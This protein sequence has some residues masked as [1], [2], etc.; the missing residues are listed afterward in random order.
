MHTIVP[1]IPNLDSRRRWVVSLMPLPLCASVETSCIYWI[2]SWGNPRAGPDALQK[3]KIIWSCQDS[4]SF[5]PASSLDTIMTELQYS[6]VEYT[7]IQH[8][9]V[10]YSKVRYSTVQYDNCTVQYSTVQYS[11]VQYST[12]QYS[13]VQCSTVQYNTVQYSTVQ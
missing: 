6:T 1:F 13:T 12:I 8:N 5:P 10:Q 3:R 2:R 4:N 9:T 7:T 11:T